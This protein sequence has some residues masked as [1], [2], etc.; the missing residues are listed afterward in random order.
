MR[1]VSVSEY[2]RDGFP[3]ERVLCS[4]IR[5]LLASEDSQQESALPST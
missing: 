3:I 2:F 1:L 4:A 5:H